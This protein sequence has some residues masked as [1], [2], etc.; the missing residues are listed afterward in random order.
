MSYPENWPRC[1]KCGDYAMDGHITC[2]RRE[3][4][5]GET[6]RKRSDDDLYR[7]MRDYG[8]GGGPVR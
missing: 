1:P 8:R 5:E 2:G 3:C 6:R 7:R 4:D